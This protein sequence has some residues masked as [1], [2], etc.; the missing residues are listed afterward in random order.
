MKQIL[1]TIIGVASGVLLGLF[2]PPSMGL[3]IALVVGIVGLL[4]MVA[5]VTWER[6]RRRS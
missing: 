4:M 6:W 2:A 1:I 5:G 3:L